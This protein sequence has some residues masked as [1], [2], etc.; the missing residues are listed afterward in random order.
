MSERKPQNAADSLTQDR[1]EPEL[2][3][4][5]SSSSTNQSDRGGFVKG[6]YVP[7]HLRNR[8]EVST[9]TQ[10]RGNPRDRER[11]RERSPP[12]A[13]EQDGQPDHHPSGGSWADSNSEDYPPPS[14]ATPNGTSRHSPQPPASNGAPASF[15]NERPRRTDSWDVGSSS[16]AP[17]H[18][19]FHGHDRRGGSG[20]WSRDA[21]PALGFRN[22]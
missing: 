1:Y 17:S 3:T 9:P 19:H 14:R 8:P 6:K 10:S 21:S 7:P 5:S 18:G 15:A 11:D 12:R 4:R 16:S 2:N 13:L 22:R 20:N